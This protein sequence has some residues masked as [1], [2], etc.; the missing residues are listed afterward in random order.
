MY[1]FGTLSVF[2]IGK[3]YYT[4]GNPNISF[5][6]LSVF[7]IGKHIPTNINNIRSF[8]TLSVFGIGK[9]HVLFVVLSAVLALFQFLV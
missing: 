1:G 8:G 6:T 2:G 7:G 5:G 4:D 9:L 3:L